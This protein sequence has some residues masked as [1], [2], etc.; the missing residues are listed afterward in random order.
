MSAARNTD[1]LI[2]AC[3]RHGYYAHSKNR[4][5]P[6]VR[7]VIQEAQEDREAL[8]AEIARLEAELKLR[9]PL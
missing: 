2:T 5:V 3:V 7:Q 6:P 4:A 9:S 1:G 8:F